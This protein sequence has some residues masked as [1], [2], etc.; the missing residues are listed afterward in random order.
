MLE[1]KF[2]NHEDSEGIWDDPQARFGQEW[3]VADFA[4]QPTGAKT[5]WRRCELPEVRV[6]SG[7]RPSLR[8]QGLSWPFSTPRRCPC[9]VCRERASDGS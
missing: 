5:G 7:M 9:V 6:A 4:R 2:D 8:T 3:D 1:D